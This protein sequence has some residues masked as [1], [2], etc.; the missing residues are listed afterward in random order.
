MRGFHSDIREYSDREEE[1]GLFSILLCSELLEKVSF[2]GSKVSLIWRCECII[3]VRA[4]Q[5]CTHKLWRLFCRGKLGK[6]T[7]QSGIELICKFPVQTMPNHNQ[8]LFLIVPYCFCLF[9]EFQVR[10]AVLNCQQILTKICFV[11]FCAEMLQQF[12]TTPKA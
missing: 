7:I 8:N 10:V 9:V 12:S 3:S 4:T 1:P 5:I 6:K 11:V 2:S